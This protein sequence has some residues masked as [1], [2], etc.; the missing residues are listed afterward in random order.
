M[1]SLFL[2]LVLFVLPACSDSPEQEDVVANVNDYE[3]TLSEF[4]TALQDEL[5]MESDYKISLEG[6]R[7]FLSSLMRR[8]VLIQEA[9]R[10][11]LDQQEDFVRTIE[12]YWESTLIRNLMQEQGRD[13]AERVVVTEEEVRDRYEELKRKNPDLPELPA[14]R[15]RLKQEL[16]EEKK[17]RRL[18]RWIQDLLSEADISVDKNLLNPDSGK[19]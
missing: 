11:N 18:E 16:T 7:E 2:V 15:Q 8:E 9:K 14:V 3:L 19:E 1:H 12:R 4:E 17:S 10:R 13:I 6:K 5:K